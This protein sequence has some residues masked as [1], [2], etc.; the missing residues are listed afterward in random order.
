[1]FSGNFIKIFNFYFTFI[2]FNSLELKTRDIII[3]E[4]ILN[5]KFYSGMDVFSAIF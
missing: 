2:G 4:D 1:M 5:F 3:L